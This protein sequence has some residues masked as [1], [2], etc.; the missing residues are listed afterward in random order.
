LNQANI[1]ISEIKNETVT[2]K[3]VLLESEAF[4]AK[5]DLKLF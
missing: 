3:K 4:Q 5:K 2:T 1:V